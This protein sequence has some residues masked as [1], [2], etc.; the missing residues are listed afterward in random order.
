M[1]DA[2][3]VLGARMTEPRLGR[4]GPTARRGGAVG[5]RLSRRARHQGV[6]GFG[7]P[8]SKAKE[9]GNNSPSRISPPGRSE[10]TRPRC[11]AL[12]TQISDQVHVLDTCYAPFQSR[13][14]CRSMS[15]NY[16][17]CSPARLCHDV[18]FEFELVMHAIQ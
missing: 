17:Y 16:T 5:G 7:S 13:R 1:K 12:V 2:K 18:L 14:D 15:R 6:G 8:P 10:G 3:V 11:S 4:S 9:R